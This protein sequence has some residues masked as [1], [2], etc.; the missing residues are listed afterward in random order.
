MNPLP[1]V[2]WNYINFIDF[3]I[4]NFFFVFFRPLKI[5][6]YSLG[7]RYKMRRGRWGVGVSDGGERGSMRVYGP[8]GRKGGRL[9]GCSRRLS[10]RQNPKFAI[11][12][13]NILLLFFI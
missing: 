3:K 7:G 5:S 4:Y 13:K 9:G 10:R 6:S 8:G 1:M 12:Q 11:L 2:L